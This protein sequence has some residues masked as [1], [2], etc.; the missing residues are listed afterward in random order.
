M[1]AADILARTDQYSYFAPRLAPVAIGTKLKKFHRKRNTAFV[2]RTQEICGEYKSP[3]QN[4]QGDF[5]HV[6]QRR[7][8]MRHVCDARMNFGFGEKRGKLILSQS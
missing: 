3:Y 6:F 1:A 8:A 5:G 7:N 2:E 4:R